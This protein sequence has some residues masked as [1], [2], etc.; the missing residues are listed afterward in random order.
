MRTFVT[1]ATGF[2]GSAVT[3]E[4]LGAGHEVVGLA[5]SDNSAAAVAA[6]GAEVHRGD[7]EDADSLRRGAA[8]ADGVLHLA[9]DHAFVDFG[10]AAAK[11]LRAI[12]AMGAALEGSG[13]P[14]VMTSGT[15]MVAFAVPGVAL[16]T[17][18]TAIADEAADQPRM[19]SEIATVAL[20]DRGVR[21]SVIRLPPTVHGAADHGFVPRLIEIA[22][23]T[24]VA[25]VLG[26]G[27]NRWPAVHRLDAA[28]L[29]RLALEEASAGSR[30]HGVDDEGVPFR[31]I[32]AAI[33]RHLDVPVQTIPEDDAPA[34]FGFLAGLVGV[35]NPSSSAQTQALL[36]WR[37]EQPSLIA[38]LEAGHYFEEAQAAA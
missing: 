12:E 38:D 23:E 1:G 34:H 11:D 28:R 21:S 29:F 37:P 24:R 22:R 33:G 15:L 7:L 27:A 13:K 6:L 19:A 18:D 20:A 26:D 9:Y 2:I 3:Q 16:A 14:F 36:G 4:L 8:A 31:D 35:D 25:G 10:A 32:A 5:R 30:L 17:E